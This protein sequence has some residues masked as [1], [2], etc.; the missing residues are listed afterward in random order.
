VVA[1]GNLAKAA[2]DTQAGVGDFV[3]KSFLSF[4]LGHQ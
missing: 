1:G 3:R 4:A 2:G